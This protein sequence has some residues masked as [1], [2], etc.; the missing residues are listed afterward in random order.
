MTIE[1]L[2]ANLANQ[3]ASR[4]AAIAAGDRLRVEAIAH[5]IACTIRVIESQKRIASSN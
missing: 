1:Q 3:R 2:E 5:S 4:D